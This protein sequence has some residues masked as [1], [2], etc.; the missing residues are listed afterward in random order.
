LSYLI[1]LR[2]DFRPGMQG[3]MPMFTSAARNQS[4]S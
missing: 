4:A 2:R 3:F 1:A